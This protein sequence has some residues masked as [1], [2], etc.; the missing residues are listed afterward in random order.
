MVSAWASD[1]NMVLGQVKVSEK[2]N[3]I[4]AI[5]ELLIS[6][7]IKGNVI[8]IDAMGCQQDIATCID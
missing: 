2:S 1:S 7:F 8:S 5:P 3:E 6:L 4:T